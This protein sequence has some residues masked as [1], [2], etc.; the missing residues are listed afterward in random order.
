[1]KEIE[2]VKTIAEV[3]LESSKNGNTKKKRMALPPKPEQE[4]IATIKH[5]KELQ[6]ELR[7]HVADAPRACL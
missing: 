6:K 2:V 3:S 4:M 7:M 1:M 5:L